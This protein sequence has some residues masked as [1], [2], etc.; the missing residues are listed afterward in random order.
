MKKHGIASSH[1]YGLLDC[2]EIVDQDGQNVKLLNLRN[3]WGT[4]EWNGDWSDK[5]D[6]WTPELK[7]QVDLKENS[8]DG[9]FWISLDDFKNYFDTFEICRFNET[10]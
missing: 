2:T 5:S 8:D 6:K 10:F 7:Q 3:P 1:S 9:L 4:F